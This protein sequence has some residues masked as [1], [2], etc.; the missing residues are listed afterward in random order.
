MKSLTIPQNWK[1]MNK[2]SRREEIV[3]TKAEVNKIKNRRI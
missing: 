3:K 2:V 1:K